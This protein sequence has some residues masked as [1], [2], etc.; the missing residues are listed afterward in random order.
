M[1]HISCGLEDATRCKGATHTKM[2]YNTANGACAAYC[3]HQAASS[4]AMEL[5]SAVPRPQT[6][7][8]ASQDHEELTEQLPPST[9]STPSR[10]SASSIPPP[11]VLPSAC[12]DA[13]TESGRS[14]ADGS[15]G[16]KS[17]DPALA[18]SAWE[19]EARLKTQENHGGVGGNVGGAGGSSSVFRLS[20]TETL[21]LRIFCGTWNVAG[22][23]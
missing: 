17:G 22:E 14:D 5:E 16:W 9:A 18:P 3:Q 12:P 20:P 10:S 4:K 23:C 6:E 1:L 7:Q 13:V 19:Q 11:S 2:P 8:A 15:C 21:D